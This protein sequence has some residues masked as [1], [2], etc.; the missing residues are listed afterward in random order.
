VTAPNSVRIEAPAKINLFLRVLGRRPDGYHDVYSLVQTVS[1]F[2]VL[3]FTRAESGISLNCDSN[4]VPCD[5]RN[6]VWKAAVLL[7]REIG[8]PEGVSIALEKR[9]PVGAGLGGG[10]SD[11]AATLKGLNHLFKLGLQ[12]LELAALA[13]KLGS[14]VTL[15]FSTGQCL[16]TGRGEVVETVKLPTDYSVLLILPDFPIST[17]WAYRQLRFPLTR[18]IA[19]PT[20]MI[21]NTDSRRFY[22]SLTDIGNDFVD[23]IVHEHPQVETVMSRLRLAGASVV[24]LSGS[25]SA[26][27]GL[28]EREPDV[29]VNAL[30]GNRIGWKALILN[31]V[32]IEPSHT[33]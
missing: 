18:R 11:A 2:D 7:D 8:L 9:I 33:Y 3:T 6:L 27:F 24:Q 16:I 17:A 22:K 30:F 29:D 20:F 13:E 28:F 1:L 31:P 10:S 14:D 12:S 21:E 32:C 4:E 15:F 23:I 5:E 26:F 19:R 25:G